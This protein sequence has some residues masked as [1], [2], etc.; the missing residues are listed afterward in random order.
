MKPIKQNIFLLFTIGI[1]NLSCAQEV[2]ST[3]KPMASIEIAAMYNPTT[4]IGAAQKMPE[5]FY[6]FR[7]TPEMRSFGELMTHI[8]SSNYIMIAIAKGE[9]APVHNIGPSKK[10]IVEALQKSFDYAAEARKNITPERKEIMVSFMGGRQPAGN[11]LD[12]NVFH[13]LSHYGNLVVYLRLK[14][15]VPPSSE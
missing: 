2:K 1:F 14:G 9:E 4:I 12:F 8:A 10:E 11:V 5:E 13:S 6:S 7:P 3:D 15:L